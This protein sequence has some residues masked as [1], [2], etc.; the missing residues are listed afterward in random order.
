LHAKNQFA[1]KMIKDKIARQIQSFFPFDLTTGQ[2]NAIQ[3]LSEFIIDKD[4]LSAMI[5]RGYAGTGKT[6]LIGGLINVLENMKLQTVLLAP[7]GR[8]AKV[9]SG[10]TKRPAFTIHKK[11]YRQKSSNDAMGEFSLDRNL[12]KNTFFIIDEAS[13]LTHQVPETTVFGSGSLLSDL[14]TYVL[15]GQNCRVVFVGDTAQLPPVGF[16][17]SPALHVGHLLPFCPKVYETEMKDVVR[18]EAGSGILANATRIRE[19]IVEGSETLPQIF[20]KDYPDIELLSGAELIEAIGDSYGKFGMDQTVVITRS[21][22]RAN[23]YNQGI[24]QAV[25]WKEEELAQ[26]DILMV[27]KNN[28]YWIQDDKDPIGFIANGDIAEIVRIH[29]YEELYGFRFA[30]VTLRFMDYNDL[31]VKTKIILDT[32]MAE[33]PSLPPEANKN[34]FYSILEDFADVKGKRNQYK[35]V[36]ENG[37]FNALQVKFAYA[38]TCHKAQGGQWKSVFVDQGYLTEEMVNTEYLRWLYTSFTRATEK[39]YLVNFSEKLFSFD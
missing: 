7:T 23:K 37:H 32:L 11:I 36:R 10:Y 27:V 31:E 26:G 28:Y 35:K 30:D 8:A 20:I 33:T 13:M 22:K 16:N 1:P 39:L 25:L 3:V 21:N 18:Q 15:N 34:L 38:V 29:G 19:A 17:N 9:L 12:H 2:L 5:V 24:R 6:T 4:P 14:F